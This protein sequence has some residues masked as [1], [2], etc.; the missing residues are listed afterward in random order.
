[1]T[2]IDRL[3]EW[4]RKAAVPTA[5]PGEYAG[6][7]APTAASLVEKYDFTQ[8]PCV[9]YGRTIERVPGLVISPRT[10]DELRATL[11][12]C[13]DCEVPVKLRG[14]A[15]SS[16]G[17]S[18]ISDG[19]QL[20]LRAL[21]RLEA[22]PDTVVAEGG[23]LWLAVVEALVP[24]NRRPPVLTDNPRTTI[25]G[26]LAV[27]GF[28]DASHRAGLQ[29]SQV[30][31]LSVATLD[32]ALHQVG[33]GDALFDYTLCGRGQLGVI[34]AATMRTVPSSYQLTARLLEW[35][36]FES[37]LPDAY[38]LTQR[39]SCDYFRAKLRW[40]SGAVWAIA[41]DFGSDPTDGLHPDSRGEA[42][43]VDYL[44]ILQREHREELIHAAP[45]LELVFPLGIAARALSQLIAQVREAGLL[46]WLDH[47]SSL[48]VVQ[49]DPRLPL[50]PI[51]SG[52]EGL[53]VAIRPRMTAEAAHACLPALLDIGRSAM[54]AGAKVYLMSIELSQP[55]FLEK[56]FGEALAPFVVLKNRWDP[57]RLLNPWIL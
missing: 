46:P 1:M 55:G 42:E 5:A 11:A 27:G 15:H 13:A 18:L 33:P 36:R 30:L 2:R 48:M 32:G 6:L 50:A 20:D 16:G 56:Q 49:P 8:S 3:Q 31:E 51:P 4:A 24:L 41:G 12:A 37:F 29:A 26:T 22:R 19:A 45:C 38:A 21:S 28:G 17:Q 34:A 39:D 57:K 10:V 47:D 43:T 9:D 44:A 23:A 53:L 7:V 25:A 52:T 54:D 35:Q 40:G 14:T